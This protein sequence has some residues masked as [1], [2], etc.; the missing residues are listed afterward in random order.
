V[1]R[2]KIEVDFNVIET[3]RNSS[4]IYGKVC[5]LKRGNNWRLEEIR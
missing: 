5:I 1:N 3:V 4:D 2:K